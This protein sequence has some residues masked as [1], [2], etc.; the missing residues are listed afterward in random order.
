MVRPPSPAKRSA[1]GAHEEVGPLLD[2]RAEKLEHVG[3][4]IA[5]VDQAFGATQP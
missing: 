5:D 3:F 2:R 1:K 4:P